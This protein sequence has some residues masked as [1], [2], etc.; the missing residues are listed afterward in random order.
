MNK[1][2]ILLSSG[3]KVEITKIVRTSATISLVSIDE[4]ISKIVVS[5][6]L[7]IADDG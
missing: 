7:Q 6:L 1:L 2:M 3:G 4:K 5:T